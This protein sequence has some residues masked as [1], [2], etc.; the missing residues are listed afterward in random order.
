PRRARGSLPV[1]AGAGPP[2]DDRR[3]GEPAPPALEV[4]VAVLG[5][6]P[7]RLVDGVGVGL[8]AAVARVGA[9]AVR[10]VRAGDAAV[11]HL[12]HI[13]HVEGAEL[14]VAV[15]AVLRAGEA[16]NAF[17]GRDEGQVLP[18]RDARRR[19]GRIIGGSRCAGRAD[20]RALAAVVVAR[21]R[22]RDGPV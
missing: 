19:A 14:V 2:D 9:V 18:R 7:E 5:E 20:A 10:V 17:D 15:L 4:R 22:A 1:I 12:T 8:E 11:L 3:A 6:H 16:I 13:L 21:A